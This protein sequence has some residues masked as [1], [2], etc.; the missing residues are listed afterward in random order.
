MPITRGR[1]CAGV[2]TGR[3]RGR[4]RRG[5]TTSLPVP[6]FT[7]RGRG[8]AVATG[9]RGGGGATEAAVVFGAA[10]VVG[11]DVVGVFGLPEAAS[12]FRAGGGVG[13]VVVVVGVVAVGEPEVCVLDVGLAG[14]A[15]EP[16]RLVVV[17]HHRR[18]R[19]RRV[20]SELS[21]LLE[22]STVWSAGEGRLERIRWIRETGDYFKGA[23]TICTRIQIG[24][25]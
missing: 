22:L 23:S 9:S 8:G 6:V 3:R 21:L 16:Q 2:F 12:G 25:G 14:V 24:I 5:G 19:R 11:E 15:L 13:L 18:R 1:A 7:R 17:S 20:S 4:R 10:L